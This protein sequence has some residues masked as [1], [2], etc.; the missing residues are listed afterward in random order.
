MTN[1]GIFAPGLLMG[2]WFLFL[3]P[4]AGLEAQIPGAEPVDVDL[5]GRKSVAPIVG[6]TR[7]G[8]SAGRRRACLRLASTL[9]SFR[10]AWA[11]GDAKGMM[12]LLHDAARVQFPG[13]SPIAGD[14]SREDMDV[15]LAGHGR[16]NSV[17]VDFGLSGSLAWLSG[18]Y[19]VERPSGC[20][21]RQLHRGLQKSR[22][23][24]A[25]SRARLRLNAGRTSGPRGDCPRPSW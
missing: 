16:L 11:G 18:R 20:T 15:V 14:V 8:I 12:E 10:H 13:L 22:I 25:D 9:A 24:L 5:D 23:Q 7:K 21:V 3:P 4:S 17:E 1:I 19:H 6:E 2:A